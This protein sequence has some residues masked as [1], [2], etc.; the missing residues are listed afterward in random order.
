MGFLS[1]LLCARDANATRELH[2]Q[3]FERHVRDVQARR[4]D[5]QARRDDDVLALKT[6]L[7]RDSGNGSVSAEL[8][9][10]ITS[11]QLEREA[12]GCACSRGASVML[13]KLLKDFS[14]TLTSEDSKSRNTTPLFNWARDSLLETACAVPALSVV[15]VLLLQDWIREAFLVQPY[16][17]I[18]AVCRRGD[19]AI[20]SRLIAVESGA[21]CLT[22]NIAIA[23]FNGC[24]I[25]C[26]AGQACV[27]DT[28]FKDTRLFSR[29]QLPELLLLNAILSGNAETVRK[30]LLEPHVQVSVVKMDALFHAQLWDAA[31]A[32]NNK[33]IMDALKALV[34]CPAY[35]KTE[36]LLRSGRQNQVHAVEQLLQAPLETSSRWSLALSA[37]LHAA[38]GAGHEGVVNALLRDPLTDASFADSH[39]LQVACANGHVP[40]VR[41]LLSDTRNKDLDDSVAVDARADAVAV[42]VDVAAATSSDASASA[43][44][45][46]PLSPSSRPSPR[47]RRCDPSAQESAALRLAVSA[48]NVDVVRLLLQDGR[49]NPR[50]LDNQARKTALLMQ[51]VD[52]SRMLEAADEP[53]PVSIPISLPLSISVPASN[54]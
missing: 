50:A 40:V 18:A 8:Q 7:L 26:R 29:A 52:I 1:Y 30:V 48:G 39:A 19:S 16:N 11:K 23:L 28:L 10:F 53:V 37:T 24:C 17:I 44:M 21:G 36:F 15:E 38:A 25:A 6:M 2:R 12:V 45:S 51:N 32:T 47:P 9:T 54:V 42:A 3:Q 22:G 35:K 41:A 34:K 31:C 33:D 5:V 43:S 27:L 14:A 13:M 46:F 20:L 4:D 49:V